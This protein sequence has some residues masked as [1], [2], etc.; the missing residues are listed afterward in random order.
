MTGT[1]EHT[2]AASPG[3]ISNLCVT[4]I[5]KDASLS[6][7]PAG[8]FLMLSLMLLSVLNPHLHDDNPFVR[9]RFSGTDHSTKTSKKLYQLHAAYL[10]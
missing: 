3:C 5:S 1:A 10:L 7:K 6:V 4:L 2:H 8:F 9:H